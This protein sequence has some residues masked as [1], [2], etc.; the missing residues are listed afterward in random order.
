[1]HFFVAKWC[2]HLDFNSLP[3]FI[4]GNAE[5]ADFRGAEA[6]PFTSAFSFSFPMHNADR[7]A[8]LFV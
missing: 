7:F 1:M 2:I 4:I 8:A 5:Q 3:D 6:Q